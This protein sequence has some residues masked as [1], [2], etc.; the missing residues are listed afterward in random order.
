MVGFTLFMS[1]SQVE[2]NGQIFPSH[3][4]LGVVCPSRPCSAQ[5]CLCKETVTDQ[6]KKFS[7]VTQPH[8]TVQ[9]TALG[10]PPTEEK[11]AYLTN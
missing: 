1:L 6:E 7:G 3:S 2:K 8:S 4:E 10:C 11:M 5:S 9:L